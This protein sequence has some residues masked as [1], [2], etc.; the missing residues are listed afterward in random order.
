MAERQGRPAAPWAHPAAATAL[1]A[2]GAA[3]SFW[4]WRHP[5][6]NPL[7][8]LRR[9]GGALLPAPRAASAADPPAA[10]G[11]G[12][13]PGARLAA[14]CEPPP[15]GFEPNETHLC[16]VTNPLAP[17]STPVKFVFCRYRFPD[18]S[19]RSPRIGGRKAGRATGAQELHAALMQATDLFSAAWIMTAKM[20]ATTDFS[21]ARSWFGSTAAIE[22]TSFEL[23][24][25][26][27]IASQHTLKI[28]DF[29]VR[30]L[31]AADRLLSFAPVN[32]NAEAPPAEFAE[33]RRLF[34]DQQEHAL[35]QPD[36]VLDPAEAAYAANMTVAI[37]PFYWSNEG[38]QSDLVYAGAADCYRSGA[39]TSPG[40][41]LRMLQATVRRQ[42]AY[43]PNRTVLGVCDEASAEAVRKALPPGSLFELAVLHCASRGPRS[44][45]ALRGGRGLPYLMM[46]YGQDNLARWGAQRVLYNEPDQVLHISNVR[47]LIDGVNDMKYIHP[48]RLEE[49][50]PNPLRLGS[51]SV[52]LPPPRLVRA[53]NISGRI[54]YKS[55][56]GTAQGMCMHPMN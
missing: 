37:M 28:T 32:C 2:V 50:P 21:A 29:W 23:I 4:L 48:H 20:F 44:S 46:D 16:P 40:Q 17:N 6:R 13:A 35:Q 54:F 34:W 7:A 39:I 38:C 18:V 19:G 41:L 1:A 22:G 45:P 30:H 49:R 8:G 33:C 25:N 14:D 3:A 15:D 27:L 52:Y 43:F 26:P 24:V 36:P 10:P 9:G 56:A 42:N 51:R 31:S 47:A 12:A 55:T 11:G 53:L 5:E